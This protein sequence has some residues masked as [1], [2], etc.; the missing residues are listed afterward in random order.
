MFSELFKRK[1]LRHS[2]TR[3]V[4]YRIT[5]TTRG[6]EDKP[7]KV[8]IV[9]QHAMRPGFV[10]RASFG[11]PNREPEERLRSLVETVLS[12]HDALN[13]LLCSASVAG[14]GSKAWE[15]SAADS[16]DDAIEKH[17]AELRCLW[18]PIIDDE[19]RSKTRAAREVAARVYAEAEEMSGV[20]CLSE[21]EAHHQLIED[22]SLKLRRK[23]RAKNVYW[24]RLEP[25]SAGRICEVLVIER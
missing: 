11:R 3:L 10:C 21:E 14:I 4:C 6:S 25:T 15:E 9:F 1:D 12:L 7:A 13:A 23:A 2:H 19:S 16:L 24:K 20:E 17:E 18:S 5:E 8:W 22:L